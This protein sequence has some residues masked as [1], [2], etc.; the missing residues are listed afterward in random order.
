VQIKG[1]SSLHHHSALQLRL[2][3]NLG[4]QVARPSFNCSILGLIL[5]LIDAFPVAGNGCFKP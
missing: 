5:F 4:R 2:K 3:R 1:G